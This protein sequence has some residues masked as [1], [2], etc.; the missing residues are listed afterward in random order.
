MSSEN[1]PGCPMCTAFS[2]DGH[3]CAQLGAFLFQALGFH[4][5]KIAFV[6]HA[7]KQ[8]IIYLL[9]TDTGH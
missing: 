4:Q 8:F 7:R 9:L 5:M 1:G 2:K 3:V 6:I